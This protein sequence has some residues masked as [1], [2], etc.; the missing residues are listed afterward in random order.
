MTRAVMGNPRF[1]S[2]TPARVPVVDRHGYLR[3]GLLL[4]PGALADS[5]LELRNLFGD[6]LSRLFSADGCDQ[7]ADSN[8]DPHPDQEGN[9][10][11]QEL[12]LFFA[13]KC[14]TGT[15]DSARCSLICVADPVFDIVHGLR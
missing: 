1:S 5:V 11:A 4:F 8:A 6:L 12:R 15:A 14:G 7:K 13:A 3:L 2:S 9:A 10:L